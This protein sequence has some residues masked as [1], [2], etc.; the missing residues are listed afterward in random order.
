MAL[1][2]T[3]E[4]LALSC[5]D[6]IHC[7]GA[8]HVAKRPEAFKH[9]VFRQ[10]DREPGFLSIEAPSNIL[11]TESVPDSAGRSKSAPESD[12]AQFPDTSK[13]LLVMKTG[14]SEAFSKVPAQ[15]TTNLKCLPEFLIFSDMEQEIGGH[16]I[17]DSL[18][19]VLDPVKT[20]NQDFDAYFRQRQCAVDQ[21]SCNRN[22][23]FKQEGWDLDK[24]KNIHI[25]EKAFNTRPNYD[26]YLFVD[27]GAYVVWPTMVRWLEQLDHND[28]M[29]IGSKTWVG[30]SPFGDGGSGYVVS[31]RAMRDFFEDEHN[32]ANRWD[33]A[34]KRH[35]C[36]DLM[37]AKALKEATGISVNDTWPTTNA[38]KPF[39]IHYSSKQWCQP[40]ATMNHLGSEELSTLCAFEREQKFA[41]PMR[42]RDLYHHFVAPRL[43]PIR[44]DWDN[45]SDDVFYLDISENSH[46]H[47]QLRKAKLEGLSP[48]EKSA[49][50]SFDSCQ[51]ACQVDSACLQYRYHDGI[52]GF[53]RTIK[54]GLPKPKTNQMSDRWMS[55]WDVDK[56][57][58]WVQEHDDCGDE[59]QWPLVQ[60]PQL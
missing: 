28:P 7:R 19:T 30:N 41:S 43:V 37:F 32:V 11:A 33:E 2:I 9:D 40:I 48:L 34:T 3:V 21:E 53:S 60:T 52:C 6:G 56:I 39:T 17:Y 42:I 29:Y 23:D 8:H 45:L 4:R 25:A 59:I 57:Q 5:T 51:R 38:E 58:A 49:H 14:A 22:M 55:G 24:Y 18:D 31:N 47:Y 46:D 54:H 26:W 36:G 20:S 27:A 15:L 1:V 13:I 35:C 50:L 10:T 16:K 44:P 12:C